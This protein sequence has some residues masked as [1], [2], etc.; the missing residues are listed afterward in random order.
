VL[1]GCESS[2]NG[3]WPH[4]VGWYTSK[5]IFISLCMCVELRPQHEDWLEPSVSQQ[6]ELFLINLKYSVFLFVRQFNNINI[7][8]HC[9]KIIW[10]ISNLWLFIEPLNT[11]F[12]GEH[13]FYQTLENYFKLVNIFW[14]LVLWKV[15]ERVNTFQN[16]DSF[17]KHQIFFKEPLHE[18]CF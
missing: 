15:L 4:H 11:S 14:M 13:N 6:N 8:L 18:D 2:K 5:I 7:F 10:C 16:I 17:K 1:L 12:N 3:L 9:R